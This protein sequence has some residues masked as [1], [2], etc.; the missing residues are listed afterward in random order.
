MSTV[1]H[2]G[3]LTV[4]LALCAGF[5]AVGGAAVTAQ[6]LSATADNAALAAADAA[7]GWIDGDPCVRA[8]EVALSGGA[9]LVSCEQQG[10]TVTVSVADTYAG[11]EV[12]VSARAGSVAGGAGGAWVLPSDGA[13]SSGYG[14]RESECTPDYCASSFHE[15]LDF[16]TG[17]GAPIYAVAAGEVTVAGSD[18]GFGNHVR[19]QHTSVL[20]S[21]YAHLQEGS[22]LVSVGES[23]VAGQVIGL[24]GD[25]GNSFGC[26]LHFEVL[27]NGTLVDPL[28]FVTGGS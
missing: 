9:T 6:R 26:H 22:L 14:P 2:L 4:A 27:V 13:Q 8:S 20:T 11:L 12:T 10:A 19:I 23:V 18:G 1:A 3:I 25:T 7:G 16:A 17:C 15:G 21:G 5:A 28:P 24:E